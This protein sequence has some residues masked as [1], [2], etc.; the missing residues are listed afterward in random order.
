MSGVASEN[1][2][3][4][5]ST[6]LLTHSADAYVLQ[7]GVVED[8]VLRAFAADSRFLH[9]AERRYF[10]ANDAG[11]E[12]NDSIFDGL[13]HPPTPR[14]IARIQICRQAEFRVVGHGNCLGFR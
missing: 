5:P 12:P 7:F 13:G 2:R 9:A 10:G 14:Q 3:N 1:S 4:R 8:P 6:G 11:V